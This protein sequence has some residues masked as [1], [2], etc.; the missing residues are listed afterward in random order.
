MRLHKK[1]LSQNDFQELAILFFFDNIRFF[2]ITIFSHKNTSKI[3]QISTNIMELLF[4]L[5]TTSPNNSE[6][7]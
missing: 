4:F 5:I 3:Y 1:N 6:R 7:R 2:P